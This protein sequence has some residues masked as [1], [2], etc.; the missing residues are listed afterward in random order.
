MPLPGMPKPPRRSARPA[1]KPGVQ[2]TRIRPRR[3]C[4]DCC[5]DIHER[6]QAVAPYPRTARWRVTDNGVVSKLCDEHKS[7]RFF[8]TE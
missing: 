5:R 6:G 3:L 1:V 4:E 8:D 7:A 2:A